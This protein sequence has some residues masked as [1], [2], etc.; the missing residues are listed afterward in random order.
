MKT[1]RNHTMRTGLA[2]SGRAAGM[3]ILYDDYSEDSGKAYTREQK[4]LPSVYNRLA[5]R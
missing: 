2:N 1:K 4:R 3:G 5:G